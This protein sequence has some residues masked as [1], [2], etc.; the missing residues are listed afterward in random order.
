MIM[1]KTDDSEEVKRT[2]RQGLGVG[3]LF[4]Q[5]SKYF[6]MVTTKYSVYISIFRNIIL[7]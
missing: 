5:L 1:S 6:K 7:W 3:V 2:R 4:V